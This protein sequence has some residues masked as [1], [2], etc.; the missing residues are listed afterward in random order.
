MNPTLIKTNSYNSLTS[1]FDSPTTKSP[2]LKSS[3]STPSPTNTINFLS[4]S[5]SS[6]FFTNFQQRKISTTS[7]LTLSLSSSS[8]LEQKDPY[9]L[10]SSPLSTPTFTAKTLRSARHIV[11]R[12]KSN[13]TNYEI[14]NPDTSNSFLSNSQSDDFSEL[15]S[16]SLEPDSSFSNEITLTCEENFIS[17]EL[18]CIQTFSS[19]SLESSVSNATTPT[20]SISSQSVSPTCDSTLTLYFTSI[21]DDSLEKKYDDILSRFSSLERNNI[22]RYLN[23]EDRYRALISILLQHYI[24]Q[25]TWTDLNRIKSDEF[26]SYQSD[27]KPSPNFP[28]NSYI[29]QRTTYNKPYLKTFSDTYYW[30]YN[31]SHHGNF[32]GIVSSH[33]NLCGLDIVDTKNRSNYYSSFSE[34]FLNFSSYFTE[35]EHH[36]ISI[37]STEESKYEIFYLLWSLKESF[38]KAVG[39]GLSFSLKRIDFIIPFTERLPSKGTIQV[40]IDNKIRNDWKFNYFFL[41][42]HH[43]ASVAQGPLN[44]ATN[45]FRSV[46]WLPI[47]ESKLENST[48][49][50]SATSYMP[51]KSSSSNNTTNS[52]LSLDILLKKLTVEQLIHKID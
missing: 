29:I 24:I 44:D 41:D 22:K 14:N 33:S 19:L 37:C 28:E 43:I 25:E 34:Y 21:K 9:K 51:S 4:S 2:S 15:Q 27:I 30:N 5:P 11:N 6:S 31:V 8:S 52:S 20:E 13:L 50:P 18:E 12:S 46:A 45:S 26:N 38:I 10:K 39:L 1:S 48:L 49:E 23:L 42:S 35:N 7:T 17:S 36:R 3:S 47:N 16:T 32:V 40:K